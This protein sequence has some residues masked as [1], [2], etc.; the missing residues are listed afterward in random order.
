MNRRKGLLYPLGAYGLLREATSAETVMCKDSM[1][2]NI[3]FYPVGFTHVYPL[4]D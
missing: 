1:H 4:I 2:D 3:Q